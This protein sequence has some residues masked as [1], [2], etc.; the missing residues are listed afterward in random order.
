MKLLTKFFLN[1]IDLRTWE[2]TFSTF[3]HYLVKEKFI[4]K[5]NQ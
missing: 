1:A 3:R 5:E 2:R 4:T